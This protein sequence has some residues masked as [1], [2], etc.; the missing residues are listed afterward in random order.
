MDPE[1]RQILFERIGAGLLVV[2]LAVGAWFLNRYE[3]ARSRDMQRMSRILEAQSVLGAFASHYAVFPPAREGSME[4][5]VAGADCI[6]K[7]GVVDRSQD[8]CREGFLGYVNSVP[9][10]GDAGLMTYATFGA[11]RQSICASPNGCLWYTIQF[12]L[13]TSALAPKGVHVVT[14][15]GLQ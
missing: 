7:A 15:E 5:G 3:Q 13:E 2:S 10:D 6:S 14:P 12:V 4:F 8:E 11:D 9:G 1:Q